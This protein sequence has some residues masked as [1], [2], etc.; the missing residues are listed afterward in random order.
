MSYYLLVFGIPIFIIGAILVLISKQP[1]QIKLLMTLMPIVLYL[2]FS[3]L[4]IYFYNYSTP[5]TILIPENVEGHLRI[6]YDENCG[7]NYEK[8]DGVRTLIFPENG[9]LLLNEEFNGHSNYNYYLVDDLGN[10]KEVPKILDFKDRIKKRPSVL[11]GGAGTILQTIEA[12]STLKDDKAIV[13][14]DFYIYN[15]DTVVR[16][17]YKSQQKF[18]SLTR[19]IVQQCRKQYNNSL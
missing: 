11:G 12:S 16:N 3:F 17:D 15:K 1:I 13:F 19:T 6:I 8:I 18:D 14:S 9:I 5:M 4:F 7:I 10:K 2:P